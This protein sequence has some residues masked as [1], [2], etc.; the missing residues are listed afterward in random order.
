MAGA[1]AEHIV[2]PQADEQSDQREDD[3]GNQKS[4]LFKPNGHG[5]ACAPFVPT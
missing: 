2:E 3:D 5:A 1:L 4:D